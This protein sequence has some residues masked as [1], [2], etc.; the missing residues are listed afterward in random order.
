[1]EVLGDAGYGVIHS[2]LFTY[3]RPFYGR[4]TTNSNKGVTVGSSKMKGKWVKHTV[5]PWTWD[6]CLLSTGRVVNILVVLAQAV[7]SL[8]LIIRR[9]QIE[10]ATLLLDSINGLYAII[11]IAIAVN[12]LLMIAIGGTW[13]VRREAQT[14][15]ECEPSL[16]DQQLTLTSHEIIKDSD[17]SSEM[18]PIQM[19]NRIRG[20]P[21]PVTLKVEPR[22]PIRELSRN[23]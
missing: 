10:G 5:E 2:L 19:R 7:A 17:G 4:R 18:A 20:K 6:S 22:S 13:E 12:S 8:V 9:R 15:P 14:S 16:R 11:G 3:S 21:V 23:K 1:M